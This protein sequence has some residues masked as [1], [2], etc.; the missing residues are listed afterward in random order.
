MTKL[1]TGSA[2]HQALSR[3][4][5][6]GTSR[7]E[8]VSPWV[9][10][11]GVD[12]CLQARRNGAEVH[13]TTTYPTLGTLPSMWCFNGLTDLEREGAHLYFVPPAH[14]LHAKI[15]VRDAAEAVVGS[16]NLT[17]HGLM[18]AELGGQVTASENLEL[19]VVLEDASLVAE[20]LSRIQH[21]P[22]R[23]WNA[24]S[25]AAASAW[26]ASQ[27]SQP[28]GLPLPLPPHPGL[29]AAIEIL[30]RHPSRPVVERLPGQAQ[31][32]SVRVGD[33]FHVY[34]AHTSTRHGA[35]YYDFEF[36]YDEVKGSGRVSGVIFI[37]VQ[38]TKGSLAEDA[39]IVLVPFDDLRHRLGHGN[40][41]ALFD[42]AEK[43]KS[44]L[45]LRRGEWRLVVPHLHDAE[46]RLAGEGPL[47]WIEP[48]P[49]S[50]WATQDRHSVPL[51]V[52]SPS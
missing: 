42:G 8:I 13:V 6:R 29:D 52:S 43:P 26:M 27:P 41:D 31:R 17:H 40:L 51:R 14:G 10:R 12:L 49:G 44:Y 15:C 20:I 1:I 16:A 23:R 38:T 48:A 18:G 39:P 24:T 37:P 19:G 5:E 50:L 11:E 21:L 36:R 34:A 32:Y 46:L 3:W 9:T 28:V 35:N 25:I 33:S 47:R 2:L 30:E 7:L 22:R 4:V 45:K